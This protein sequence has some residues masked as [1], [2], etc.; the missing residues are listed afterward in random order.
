M[1]DLYAPLIERTTHPAKPPVLLVC[2]HASN[3]IPPAF[4]NLGL[5]QS[6]LQTHIAWD[7]GALGVARALR[8]A[9]NADLVAS[10]VSRLLYD[11]NRPPESPGAM[12]ET[13]EIYEIP[14]NKA[15]TQAERAART[16]AIYTPFRAALA[17]MMD[18]Y[19][20]A[21]M[22]T[23]HSFTPIYH[24]QPRRCE[25]GV[26]HDTDTRLADALLAQ[27]PAEFPHKLERNVPYSASDGVTHTLKTTALARGWPN[28]MLEIRND[29][30]ATAPQQHTMALALAQL[31]TKAIKT[32][33]EAGNV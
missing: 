27:P 30:I 18:Q 1:P 4:A 2:E 14:G 28:V 9:L 7:P 25:I 23:V 12:P 5:P 6:T 31:L 11:C 21:I 16:A 24:G 19:E 29:L 15:L 8:A 32:L 22:V 10:T 20:T 17:D 26:L 13:S 3:H 33:K